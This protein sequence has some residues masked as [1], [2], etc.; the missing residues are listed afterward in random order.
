MPSRRLTFMMLF[1][2][3]AFIAG[4]Y[5]SLSQPEWFFRR[6]SAKEGIILADLRQKMRTYGLVG[7]PVNEEFI[8][9]TLGAYMAWLDGT[10]GVR[11]WDTLPVYL[12][13][14]Q[15]NFPQLNIVDRFP[16]PE[17]VQSITLIIDAHTG[18]ELGPFG[19]HRS[20]NVV[21]DFDT[22]PRY[23]EAV[24]LRLATPQ[25]YQVPTM[26][27]PEITQVVTPAE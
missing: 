17:H 14:V 10:V 24:N 23:H 5:V 7:E 26:F 4:I 12:Y 21:G 8:H 16:P 13:H 25:P 20:Y 1:I 27:S 11:Y 18:V 15:G 3:F 9:T 19:A 6:L 22:L 2:A